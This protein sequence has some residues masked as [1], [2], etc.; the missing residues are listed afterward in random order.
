MVTYCAIYPL[1][2]VFHMKL[3]NAANDIAGKNVMLL[4]ENIMPQVFSEG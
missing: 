3:T 2:I 1:W 4:P